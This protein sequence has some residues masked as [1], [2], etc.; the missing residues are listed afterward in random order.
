MDP[1]KALSWEIHPP[2]ELRDPCDPDP[3]PDLDLALDPEI[4]GV[5]PDPN[6]VAVTLL[7]RSREG[8]EDP[9]TQRQEIVMQTQPKP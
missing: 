3:D 1:H 9:Q 8:T 7:R 5:E 4:R 2:G 6:P